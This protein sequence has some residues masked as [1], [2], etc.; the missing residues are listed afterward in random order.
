MSF[1]NFVHNGLHTHVYI[2]LA[3]IVL[4]V[5]LILAYVNGRKQ[6]QRNES[7]EEELREIKETLSEQNDAAPSFEG[8]ATKAKEA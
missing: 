3:A 4:I 1:W 6:K 2:L 8:A 7:R 5:M